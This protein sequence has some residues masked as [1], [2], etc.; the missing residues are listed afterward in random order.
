MTYKSA[1]DY[2]L[3][4][5]NPSK[6]A[7]SINEY[8]INEELSQVNQLIEGIKIEHEHKP[9]YDFIAKI[10]ADTGKLP[11]PELVYKHIAEDHLHDE[12]ADKLYYTHLVEMLKKYSHEKDY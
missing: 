4:G 7:K 6:P 3:L 5:K 8:T 11:D 12:G 10:L 2:Y 9:T 1:L